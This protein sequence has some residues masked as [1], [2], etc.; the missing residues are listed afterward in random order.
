MFRA[1]WIKQWVQ[2]RTLR[3]VGVGLC[4]A[5][6]FFLWSGAAAAKRGWF[7]FSVGDYSLMTLFGEAL[8]GFSILLWTF[9]AV[10]FA[11]QSFAGDRSDGTDRFL[12]ERPVP[13]KRVWVARALASLASALAVALGSTVYMFG[14]I[15][16]VDDGSVAGW[17]SATLIGW[18]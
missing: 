18:K 5:L 16:L 1:L 17:F 3:W 13:R 2:E 15:A 8:P 14:L 12:L 6:P 11:A 4:V 10:M 7:P 9:L